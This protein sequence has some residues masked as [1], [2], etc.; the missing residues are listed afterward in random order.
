LERVDDRRQR[1]LDLTTEREEQPDHDG[2][3]Q[4]EDDPVLGHCLALVALHVVLDPLNG[5]IEHLTD[6]CGCR[7]VNEVTTWS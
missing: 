4:R 6:S 3:D 2:G 7:Y 1:G 5:E